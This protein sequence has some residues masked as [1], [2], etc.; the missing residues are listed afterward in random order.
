MEV[1]L[2]YLMDNSTITEEDLQYVIRRLWKDGLRGYD[3][4]VALLAA[5]RNAR[6]DK[7]WKTN[8]DVAKVASR[9]ISSYI[10]YIEDDSFP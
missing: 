4:M 5:M 1:D 3:L 8:Y 7:Y 9:W 2:K 10:D 6:D